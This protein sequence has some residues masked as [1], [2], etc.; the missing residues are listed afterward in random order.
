[1]TE[2]VRHGQERQLEIMA[3]QDAIRGMLVDMYM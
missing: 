1:L 2:D 3:K